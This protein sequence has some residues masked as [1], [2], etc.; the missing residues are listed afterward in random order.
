MTQHNKRG[1]KE[2]MT[3][4]DFWGVLGYPIRHDMTPKLET[5][6][7]IGWSCTIG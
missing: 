1:V 7:T 4:H 6:K 3:Q 2:D 5:C